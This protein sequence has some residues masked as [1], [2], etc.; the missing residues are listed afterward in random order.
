M[1]FEAALLDL[2][3]T[4][5]DTLP[6]LADAANAMLLDLGLEP[7]EQHYIGSIIGKGTE[8]LVRRVLAEHGNV[9]KASAQH[10]EHAL[11]LFIE[12]YQRLNGVR[13][14]VYPGTV[15]GL[16]AFRDAGVRLAVVTNKLHGFAEPLLERTGLRS[17][18]SL[19]VGGDTCERRKPDPMPFLHACDQLAVS[20][21]N[22]L[23]I[24]D[25]VNDALA[26]RAAGITVLA[27]PYGYNEGLN[28]HDL[29][30]DAI[31]DS[32]QHAAEWAQ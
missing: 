18:F 28:V 6:D 30:V 9:Q 22:A 20:P 4:L 21:A 13:S 25:S 2:D 32:V 3:G 11:S 17:Y 31:V 15:Q 8:N 12:H 7:V 26:A 10:P 27:V 5:I 29:D 23:A 19:V 24:G 14:Q 16:Q 1:R